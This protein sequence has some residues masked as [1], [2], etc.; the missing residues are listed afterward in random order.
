[1]GQYHPNLGTGTYEAAKLSKKWAR[2]NLNCDPK[3]YH[4][5]FFW[6]PAQVLI[7]PASNEGVTH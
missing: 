2:E 6:G 1:M 5:R 7:E 3:P 4:F